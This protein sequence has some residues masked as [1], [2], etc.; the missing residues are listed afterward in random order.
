[1]P[2]TATAILAAPAKAA[3]AV[4]GAKLGREAIADTA[5][6]LRGR[7]SQQ[8]NRGRSG[9]SGAQ[10]KEAIEDHQNRDGQK[11]QRPPFFNEATRH[12]KVPFENEDKKQT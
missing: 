9:L 5:S 3:N 11:I 4:A 8:L 10:I 1:M 2:L 7:V 12:P 6:F